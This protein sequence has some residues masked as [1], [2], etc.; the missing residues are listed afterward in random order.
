MMSKYIKLM[1]RPI[2]VPLRRVIHYNRVVDVLTYVRG[3]NAAHRPFPNG[4]L[5]VENSSGGFL[6]K[7]IELAKTTQIEGKWLLV[8]EPESAPKQIASEWLVREHEILPT[9]DSLET[10]L[11]LNWTPKDFSY[12]LCFFPLM[13][14]PPKYSVV[15]HQSVLEHVVDPV[16]AIRN[17]NDFLVPGGIQVIQTKNIYSSMHRYPIDTLRY[18]PDFFLSLGNY[19]PVKCVT[20]FMENSSIYAVLQN[21]P[22]S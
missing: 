12:D 15:M 4:L 22:N 17:L 3:V 18:F 19:I 11:K 21:N 8:S 10:V 6:V 14:N 9:I 5:K 7:I 1:L 20:T 16:T 2:T 13:K